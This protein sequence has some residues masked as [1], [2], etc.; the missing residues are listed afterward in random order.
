MWLGD[1]FAILHN[2]PATSV[3]FAMADNEILDVMNASFRAQ[4]MTGPYKREGKLEGWYR[5]V[6]DERGVAKYLFYSYPEDQ[7][8]ELQR[9]LYWEVPWPFA[10][11]D[12]PEGDW[13]V[14]ALSKRE[15][16]G[17][18]IITSMEKVS[19]PSIEPANAAAVPRFDC[20]DGNWVNPAVPETDP[21]VRARLGGM[22]RPEDSLALWGLAA[23]HSYLDEDV[24]EEPVWNRISGARFEA[25]VYS[26]AHGLGITPPLLGWVTENG[27]DRVVGFA[28]AHVGGRI[29]GP[30]DLAECGE[31]LARLHALRVHYGTRLRRESFIIIEHNDEEADGADGA[32]VFR[33][34]QDA[35]EPRRRRVLMQDFLDAVFTDD[36]EM[37]AEEMARLPM[38]LQIEKCGFPIGQPFRGAK[39]H[40]KRGLKL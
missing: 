17:R 24:G 9:T 30:D 31:A 10:F 16:D 25:P 32:G 26:A 2:R 18:F 35:Q 15:G 38:A 39:G 11:L 34:G 36:K 28:V 8:G 3:N 14:G 27:G 33:G 19:L 1:A 13:N 6:T 21:Q 7:Q 22:F 4:W 23:V 29:A 5:A 37:F 12:L 40:D 20:G